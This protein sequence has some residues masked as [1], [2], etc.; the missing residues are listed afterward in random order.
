MGWS[1]VGGAKWEEQWH[2]ERQGVL[3]LS[4]ELWAVCTTESATGETVL[5]PVF[6]VCTSSV[7][8]IRSQSVK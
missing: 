4:R 8:L 7:A 6:D 5:K 1:G 2:R 3:Y